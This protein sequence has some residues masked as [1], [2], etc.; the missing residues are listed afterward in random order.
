MY[1]YAN[2][3]LLNIYLYYI[4][5]LY[6]YETFLLNDINPLLHHVRYL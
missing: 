4:A 1:K 6:L 2:I 5:S 3:G